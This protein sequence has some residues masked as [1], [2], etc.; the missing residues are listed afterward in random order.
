MA[1]Q[2]ETVLEG[3]AFF[4]CPRWHEGR[5]YVSDFYRYAVYAVDTDGTAEEFF[6]VEGQPS[7]IGWLPDGSLIVVS[8]RE[9]KLFRRGEDGS[10]SVH[11]DLTEL[12]SSDLNDMV[13]SSTGHAYVGEFGFDTM[14]PEDPAYA[15]LF[16]VGPDG[17]VSREFDDLRFPNGSVITPDGKTL[18]VGESMAS[19][20]TAFDIA[21]DGTLANSRVWAQIKPSPPFEPPTAELF[22][23][24]GMAI[25]GCCLDAENHIWAA[26][27]FGAR[28]IRVAPGGKIVDELAAPADTGFIA[29]ALGGTDR[30]TLLIAAGP[31]EWNE[32]V[33][34]KTRDGVLLS[35]QVEV[36]GAGLP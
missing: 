21:E 31:L 3:G 34:S 23:N 15:G 17:S 9:R 5:W 36:P 12:A 18:I 13:V 26:D 27:A 22:A 4:E 19:R 35:T 8:K 11:A 24:L 7:G 2:F 10:S 20:Y 30:R 29:C 14:I 32:A 16:R 28:L 33:R 1:E 6:H 25:D